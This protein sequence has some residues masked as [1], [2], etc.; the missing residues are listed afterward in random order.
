MIEGH[1]GIMSE[2]T[3]RSPS[4]SLQPTLYSIVRHCRPS[5]EPY[6]SVASNVPVRVYRPNWQSQAP[7][8]TI[9]PVSKEIPRL[10]SQASSVSTNLEKPRT[11]KDKTVG[12]LFPS[13]TLSYSLDYWKANLSHYRI[14]LLSNHHFQMVQC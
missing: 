4:F 9:A 6:I 3:Y 1:T 8:P 2:S 5:H 13:L 10:V 12:T 7:I 14:H 11:S